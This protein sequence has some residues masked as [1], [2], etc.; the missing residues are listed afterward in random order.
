VFFLVLL[1]PPAQG[2]AQISPGP[3]SAAH[4]NLEGVTNCLKCHEVGKTQVESKCL[5]CHGEI[6][7]LREQ[8]R[9]FHARGAQGHCGT[10]HPE[11]GGRDFEII[12]WPDG[13]EKK[14]DHARAGWP[15]E[16]KH[17]ETR[18]NDC[19]TSRFHDPDVD[20]MRPEAS[21]TASWVGLQRECA[22]C[23][24]DPHEGRF[25]LE[26]ASCH[27][28]TS[29]KEMRERSFDHSQTRYPL[30]GKHASV[31]CAKCHRNG[32]K[33]RPV[34]ETCR[35][36]HEDPHKGQATLAGAQQDCS[37]CHTVEGFTPSTFDVARHAESTYPLQGRHAKVSCRG[38]HGSREG[39]FRFRLNSSRCTDC[40]EDAHAGQLKRRADGG[41]CSSCHTV[42]AFSDVRF[43]VAD[44]ENLRFPLWGAHADAECRHCHP[45][46]SSG[47]TAPRL[48]SAGVPLHFDSFECVACHVEPHGETLGR[49]DED[50]LRC[51]TASGFTPSLVDL[52]MHDRFEYALDGSHRAV[53]CFDCH[54]ALKEKRPRSTLMD[55]ARLWPVLSFRVADRTCAG[56]HA[57]PHGGQFEEGRKGAACSG[58]HTTETFRPAV[59]FDHDRDARFRLQGAHA[60]VACEKCHDRQMWTDDRERV[61]YRPLDFR[62]EDCHSP[63]TVGEKP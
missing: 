48:G 50:C 55:A 37:A 58:C 13:D 3:L 53:A 22:A 9:G 1:L 25:G 4:E 45:R 5:A 27:R 12:A 47:E 30:A 6:A 11:H 56:C 17:A 52:A 33:E 32:Y 10:C 43:T 46:R 62:C 19:H 41:E 42:Q 15:L 24:K 2:V 44:H 54:G 31:E 16:G 14:F 8:Q 57:D 29:W 59:A 28:A 26:C 49:R 38:C 61:V 39:A 63:G 36:C 51:H 34:F 35:S 40:H 23:H 7:F 60:R 21:Q 18:C 20:R